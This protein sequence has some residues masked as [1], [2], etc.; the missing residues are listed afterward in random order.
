M[1]DSG[2]TYQ[3]SPLPFSLRFDIE[4]DIK[5]CQQSFI[6]RMFNFL[7]SQFFY[8]FEPRRS[9]SHQNDIMR[10]I[11]SRLGIRFEINDTID[12][13]VNDDFIMLLRFV[14]GLYEA[15]KPSDKVGSTYELDELVNTS[16]SMNEMDLGFVWRAGHFHKTGAGLLDKELINNSIQWL[17]APQYDDVLSPFNRLPTE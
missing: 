13:Y 7:E 4:T 9:Y 16:I 5:T 1:V 17:S 12:Q 6:N 14:E 11:S 3:D 10:H 15:L 2:K 8:L